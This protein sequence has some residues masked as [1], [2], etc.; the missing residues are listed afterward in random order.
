MTLVIIIIIMEEMV[1]HGRG[2]AVMLKRRDKF[3]IYLN[4]MWTTAMV[5]VFKYHPANDLERT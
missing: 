5:T 3:V 4:L 1:K 2:M